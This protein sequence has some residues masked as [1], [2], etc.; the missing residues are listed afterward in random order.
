MAVG[1]HR[2]N[3]ESKGNVGIKFVESLLKN[4]FSL[5]KTDTEDRSPVSY[6]LMDDVPESAIIAVVK[7]AV[8]Y[9]FNPL[10]SMNS[11]PQEANEQNS[12]DSDEPD[13]EQSFIME[14]FESGKMTLKVFKIVQPLLMQ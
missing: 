2:T 7:L 10:H 8:K 11:Q 3:P 1:V 14:L 6:I 12:D 9:G 13:L 4:K 5:Y